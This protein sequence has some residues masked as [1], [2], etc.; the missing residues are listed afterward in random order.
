MR[1]LRAAPRLP[2]IDGPWGRSLK[3]L[4]GLWVCRQ[5]DQPEV[6][7]IAKS[8]D[9]S[10]VVQCIAVDNIV[11]DIKAGYWL[12]KTIRWLAGIAWPP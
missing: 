8:D 12:V 4:R 1:S 9:S 6:A 10:P 7:W 2:F 11:S 3:P 5:R